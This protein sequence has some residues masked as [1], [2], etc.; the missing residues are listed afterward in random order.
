MDA[1]LSAPATTKPT[2]TTEPKLKQVPYRVANCIVQIPGKLVKRIQALEY[3]DMRDLLPYNIALAEGL[4]ALP[5]GLAP[6]R[7]P[8]ER[9]IGGDQALLTWVSSFAT[10]VAIVAEA[11]PK[12]VGDMLAY[13]RLTVRE[14]GKF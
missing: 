4:A 9:E 8:G 1:P 12:R 2:G 3:V 7:P 10:Y 6:P 13:L 14:A 11:Y 5:S